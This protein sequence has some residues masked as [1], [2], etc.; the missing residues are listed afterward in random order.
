MLLSRAFQ[1]LAKP[2]TTTKRVLGRVRTFASKRPSLS[3]SD[4][5]DLV[6]RHI[7]SAKCE[8]M[9]T[10]TARLLV[11]VDVE[12]ELSNLLSIQTFLESRSPTGTK[13]TLIQNRLDD[14]HK[15]K[16]QVASKKVVLLQTADQHVL[17]QLELLCVLNACQD[18]LD[19]K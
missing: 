9:Q 13:S 6:G 15:E 8:I 1:S 10:Q 11:C 16:G 19:A 14:I 5:S 18:V 12:D 17:S 3:R 2:A 7:H 4:L